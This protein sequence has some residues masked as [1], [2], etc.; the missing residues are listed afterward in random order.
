MKRLEEI[1]QELRNMAEKESMKLFRIARRA[2]K[3]NCSS[4]LINSIQE[5][6]Y[7]LLHTAM[8]YP[9]RI[10][11]WDFEYTHKYMFK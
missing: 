2:E 8:I 3:K 10:L 5:E 1:K 7:W 6:A 11:K 9:E 4:E